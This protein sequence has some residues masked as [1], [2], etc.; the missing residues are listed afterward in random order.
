MTEKARRPRVSKRELRAWAWVA[1]ALAF[2]APAAVLGAVP[3][4]PQEVAGQEQAARPRGPQDHPAGRRRSAFCSSA[5]SVH[6]G[7]HRL[8]GDEFG[9][10]HPGRDIDGRLV[11]PQMVRAAFRAM[12]TRVRCIAPLG[13]AAVGGRTR[14]RDVP[15]R[16]AA[17]LAV[18]WRQRTL[19]RERDRRI[20]DNRVPVFRRARPIRPRRLG[21]NRGPLRSH[22]AGRDDRRRVRPG[23][24]RHRGRCASRAPRQGLQPGEPATFG[25]TAAASG[26]PTE[27]RSISAASRRDG[28]STA[29]PPSPLPPAC[30]GP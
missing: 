1:G 28:P 8:R 20:V 21:P 11:M 2:L 22:A 25:W 23:L 3:K 5:D 10:L 16:G 4:P 6:R 17:L 12:G 27:W 26:S 18:P 7:R 29:P 30:R 15:T 14:P 24:R 19:A 9:E 13:H